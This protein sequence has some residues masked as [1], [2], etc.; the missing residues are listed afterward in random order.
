MIVIILFYFYYKQTCHTKSNT[1][2]F[3][4]ELNSF[5]L[6]LLMLAKI[7]R[8]SQL[9]SQT[10]Q[11][12]SRPQLE[13]HYQTLQCQMAH[14]LDIAP[15]VFL[16][17]LVPNLDITQMT[18]LLLTTLISFKTCSTISGTPHKSVML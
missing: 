2:Q 13:V 7:A 1:S 15:K 12:E 4:E 9:N 17:Y 18:Q 8:E 10:G 5:T 14:V 16:D 6:C 3:L 11:L